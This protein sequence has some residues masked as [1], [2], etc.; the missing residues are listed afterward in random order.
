MNAVP[1]QN[2]TILPHEGMPPL[3]MEGRAL[4][5]FED[6]RGGLFYIP[7]GLY[8]L[9]LSIKYR[10]LTL[11]TLSNPTI[12]AGG[13]CGETKTE[14]LELLGPTG[15]K[16]LAPFVSITVLSREQALTE[17]LGKMEKAGI[18]FPVMVKPNRGR[19]GSGV[20][21]VR[22]IDELKQYLQEFPIGLEL[23]FQTYVPHEGEAGIFYM[24]RPGKK[25]GRIVSLPL[26]YFP[27]VTG[28][29]R[30]TL[31]E[32][33]QKDKRAGRLPHLYLPRHTDMLEKIIPAG[34][35]FRLVFVGN[36]CKGAIFRDGRP[37]VTPAME[38][39]FDA[40]VREMP[41]FNYGRFDVR[42]S[43]LENLQRGEGFKI[44]E[45]NGAGSEATHIWDRKT[46]LFEAYR[47]L[48]DQIRWAFEIGAEYRK[49]NY[50]ALPWLK[51]LSLYWK[52]RSLLSLYP[53]DTM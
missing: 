16:A 39:H 33:I 14:I 43:S 45:L 49:R 29:G 1:T 22:T 36:H 21:L 34:E 10:S 46:T 18:D 23:I 3:D 15:K 7:V 31:R 19:R 2:K 25:S 8:W 9:W 12:T 4:S 28:D 27:F 52:E 13:L 5:L 41:D 17:G 48:F 11:P 47:G 6:V 40:I 38:E 30:R 26:K 32:L 35:P 37:Y 51:V 24:R 53:A 42:F 44:I 50:R 20:R